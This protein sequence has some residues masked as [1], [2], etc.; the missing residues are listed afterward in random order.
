MNKSR[1]SLTLRLEICRD[2]SFANGG[3]QD[4]N[5]SCFKF[6]LEWLIDICDGLVGSHSMNFVFVHMLHP[7]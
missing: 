2:P 3:E 4:L 1:K 7:W 5:W 6:S